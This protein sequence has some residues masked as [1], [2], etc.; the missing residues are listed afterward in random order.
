[1]MT[2][3]ARVNA[4]SRNKAPVTPPRKPIGAYTAAKV[5]VI[6]M[7]GPAIS[8]APIRAA[9]AGVRHA[10]CVLPLQRSA[11]SG[12][13]PCP[14]HERNE[15]DTRFTAKAADAPGPV[16][17]REE[18]L[19]H[20]LDLQFGERQPL[21]LQHLFDDRQPRRTGFGLHAGA[22]FGIRVGTPIGPLRLDFG[23]S[24]EGS[25]THFS[26]GNVF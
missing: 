14:G 2:A 6:E 4:N 25:R 19:L 5:R 21:G 12:R 17:L 8:R 7:T 13:R 9:C 22:G 11:M 26:I 23:F 3:P 10:A 15:H 20:P 16:A 24:A 18:R 1:M